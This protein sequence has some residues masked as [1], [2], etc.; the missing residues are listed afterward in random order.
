MYS[1][2][3]MGET[4][5]ACTMNDHPDAE[6]PANI[7]QALCGVFWIV[8]PSSPEILLPPGSI[9]EILIQGLHV[10]RRYL[11]TTNSLVSDG[12]LPSAPRRRSSP[13]P[14]N[15]DPIPSRFYLSGDI[16]RWNLD[17]SITHPGRGDVMLKLD[18]NQINAVEVGRYARKCLQPG[19]CR[20]C[21]FS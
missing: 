18:G 9:G 14:A 19:G 16:G 5:I 11:P 12:F 4:A 21:G 6:D 3:G 20:D 17:G 8:Q 2:D 1:V 7:G 13:A 10:A 15:P